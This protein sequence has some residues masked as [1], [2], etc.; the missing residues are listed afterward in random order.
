MKSIRF[1][2]LLSVLAVLLGTAIAKSQT[3]EDTPAPPP[4]H[5]HYGMHGH[6]MGFFARHGKANSIRPRFRPWPLRK[7]SSKPN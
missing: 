7:P 4:M 5:A 6:M 1:R 3:T 2:L